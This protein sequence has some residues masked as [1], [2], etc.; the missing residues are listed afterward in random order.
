MASPSTV[1]ILLV[2]L[3]PYSPSSL[4]EE[5]IIRVFLSSESLAVNLP[6][7][8]AKT[9]FIL[10]FNVISILS[11]N[12]LFCPI[13][14]FSSIGLS[15]TTFISLLLMIEAEFTVAEGFTTS[16]IIASLTMLFLASAFVAFLAAVATSTTLPALVPSTMPFELFTTLM[17]SGSPPPMDQ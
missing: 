16:I 13:T 4:L 15:N 10:R 7:S 3:I 8:P 5:V 9:P 17:H 1:L 12:I 2:K 11:S 6:G 14:V